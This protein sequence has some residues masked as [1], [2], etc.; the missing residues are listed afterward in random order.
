MTINHFL[1]QEKYISCKIDTSQPALNKYRYT[2]NQLI[3]VIVLCIHSSSQIAHLIGF[4]E[5]AVTLHFLYYVFLSDCAPGWLLVKCF[6]TD[7]TFEPDL[8][9]AAFSPNCNANLENFIF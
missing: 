3:K 6:I 1:C 5:C 4:F 7:S 8:I 9:F 2:E